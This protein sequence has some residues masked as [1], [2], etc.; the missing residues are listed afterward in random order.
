MF[1]WFEPVPLIS[2]ASHRR[3]RPRASCALCE[4][5]RGVVRGINRS[6]Q[7]RLGQGIVGDWRGPS[8]GVFQPRIFRSLLLSASWTAMRSLRPQRERSVPLGKYW[9]SRPLVFSFV[10]RCHGGFGS[11]KKTLMPASIVNCAW[12]DSSMPRSQVRVRNSPAGMD[13]MVDSR[14][15]F[16]AMAS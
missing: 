15:S 7:H 12:A 5:P 3:Q 6:W 14:A 1:A 10:A 11:A 16:M 13:P 9:R 4:R 8:A 2:D